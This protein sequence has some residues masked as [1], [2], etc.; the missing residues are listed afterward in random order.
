[1][2]PRQ[3]EQCCRCEDNAGPTTDASIAKCMSIE[4]FVYILDALED[5]F[6]GPIALE[7]S[8]TFQMF[9]VYSDHKSGAPLAPL[10]KR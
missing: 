2:L 5:V 7:D 9:D 8:L 4:I 3:T 6:W 10:F 1:M